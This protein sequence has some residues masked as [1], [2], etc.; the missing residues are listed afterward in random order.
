MNNLLLDCWYFF[1]LLSFIYSFDL[2]LFASCVQLIALWTFNQWRRNRPPPVVR[3]HFC[4][5][6]FASCSKLLFATFPM[7][8]LYWQWLRVALINETYMIV[9]NMF[10]LFHLCMQHETTSCKSYSMKKKK[11]EIV[12]ALRIRFMR[13]NYHFKTDEK[14]MSTLI[15]ESKFNSLSKVDMIVENSRK[16][17]ALSRCSWRQNNRKTFEI[18][19]SRSSVPVLKFPFESLKS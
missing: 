2:D 18:N 5:H 14:T 4:I 8:C 7:P 6:R 3:C 10:S 13:E 11:R 9:R 15:C 12:H 16:F 1:P 17:A 19:C